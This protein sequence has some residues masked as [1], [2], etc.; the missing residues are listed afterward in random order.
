MS[1]ALIAQRLTYSYDGAPAPLFQD[2]DLHVPQGWTGVVGPNGSG[3]TTLLQLATGLLVP[4]SGTIRLPEPAWYCPQRTDES[5]VDFPAL[6]ESME[7][8]SARIRSRLGIG[9][10]WA[11]RWESLSHGE[12]K[13]AQIAVALASDPALLAIDEPTNHLDREARATLG[14]ALAAFRGVG[15]LVSHDRELLDRLCT[16]CLFLEP[17]RPSMRSGGYTEGAAQGERERA[18]RRRRYL[19]SARREES[20]R[21]EMLRRRDEA[22]RADRR[23]SKRG[24]G[25]HDSD[26]KEK[27]DRARVSGKDGQAGRLAR[28]IEGRHLRAH[29]DAREAYAPAERAIRFWMTGSV[30]RGDA[31]ARLDAGEIPLGEGRVLVHPE[32]RIRGTDRVA[33]CGPNGSGKS[34]LVHRMVSALTLPA[35]RLVYLPQELSTEDTRTLVRQVREL[36]DEQRGRLMTVVAGLG[37]EPRQLLASEL[38]SPGETRK[39]L[40]GLGVVREP[41]LVVMD[42]PTN[43]LDLPSI[44]LLER[45][46]AA[47]PGALLLVS[48]DEPF[49]AA[50]CRDRWRI[51]STDGRRFLLSQEALEPR[52]DTPSPVP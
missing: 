10:D 47:C 4:S 17:P 41:W 2:L 50:A 8:E 23:R 28:Q 35:D 26:G 21:R 40:L 6:T 29:E 15:I 46:L 34:S 43:H 30:Y 38:P 9:P 11:A 52:L 48:H 12:R 27:I 1:S 49:L 44:E 3:K 22:S 39:L 33:L 13:R 24:L 37:S 25:I 16:Q 36:P 20:L 51:R 32:L 45:A 19:E 18:A 7:P 31:A 42:E 14:D 5:P